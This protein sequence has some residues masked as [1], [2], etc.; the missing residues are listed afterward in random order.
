MGVGYVCK[1]ETSQIL[2]HGTTSTITTVTGVP[3]TSLPSWSVPEGRK[4][5]GV[6]PYLGLRVHN[7]IVQTNRSHIE[8]STVVQTFHL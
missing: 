6:F 1:I 7:I 2:T 3:P 4:T 5:P 8:V